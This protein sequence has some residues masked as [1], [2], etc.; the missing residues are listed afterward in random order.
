LR[1]EFEK[2]GIQVNFVNKNIKKMKL[3]EEIKKNAKIFQQSNLKKIKTFSLKN[4]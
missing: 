2:E 1:E 3:P 4:I